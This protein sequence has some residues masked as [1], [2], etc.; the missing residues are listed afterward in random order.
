MDS[1]L[2]Y[3]MTDLQ[4]LLSFIL[5]FVKKDGVLKMG[6][7]NGGYSS[8]QTGYKDSGGRKVT[9]SGSIFVAER[10]IDEG[11][12]AVFRQRHDPDTSCDL[13]IKTSDDTTIVKNIEVKRITASNPSKIA[14]RIKEANKQIHPGDT[15]AIVLPNQKNNEQGRLFASTGVSEARRKGLILGPIEIWFSD[16]TKIDY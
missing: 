11:Y 13:T 7:G 15:I 1:F 6:R 10:Y 14:S 2:N 9:D 8:I 3:G 12:E 5:R 16:K 4:S